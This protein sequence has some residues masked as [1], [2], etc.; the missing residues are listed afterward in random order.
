M[1]NSNADALS[2]SQEDY[3]EAIFHIVRENQVARVRD[4]SKRLNVKSS[5]VTGALQS[6]SERDLINYAPY[7]LITMKPKGLS[8][9]KN[10]VRRHNALRDFFI[11]V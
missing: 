9:A 11:K 6:L 8:L 3:L 5:S 7:D 1:E 10:I 4:I 2:A